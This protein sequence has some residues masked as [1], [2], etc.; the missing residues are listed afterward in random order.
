[1]Y[2]PNN[3]ELCMT[4]YCYDLNQ[5]LRDS[6]L[7]E[8]LS[9]SVSRLRKVKRFKKKIVPGV[10][11]V[12][13]VSR[14]PFENTLSSFKSSLNT[15]LFKQ[16]YSV[17]VSMFVRACVRMCVC[18]CVC[19]CVCVRACI[20]VCACVCVCVLCVRTCVCVFVRACV[21]VRECC[22]CVYMCARTRARACVCGCVCV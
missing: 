5:H 20:Y 14:F 1:M 7:K 16:S 3:T 2:Q 12:I 22:M 6:Y 13:R 11:L 19:A 21:F 10:L 8:A 17:C 9:D 15:Y 4:C 18:M